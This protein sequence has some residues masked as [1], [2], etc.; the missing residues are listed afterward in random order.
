MSAQMEPLQPVPERVRYRSIL[1]FFIIKR[2]QLSWLRT[3]T[4]LISA[5]SGWAT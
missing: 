1:V 3:T 5:S 2:D 4:V